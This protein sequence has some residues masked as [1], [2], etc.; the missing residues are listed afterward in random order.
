MVLRLQPQPDRTAACGLLYGSRTLPPATGAIVSAAPWPR[1][2]H[3][4][5][6]R[7]PGWR[8]AF[9]AS[10]RPGARAVVHVHDAASARGAG[11][12]AASLRQRAGAAALV[13]A[14]ERADR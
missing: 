11:L 6:A 1:R 12:L 7:R 3:R 2:A 10:A 4:R 9:F 8:A 13:R 5:G 14:P